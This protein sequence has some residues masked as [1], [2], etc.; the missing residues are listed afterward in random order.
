M[1]KGLKKIITIISCVSVMLLCLTFC[2]PLFMNNKE[3]NKIEEIKPSKG[4][5]ESVSIYYAKAEEETNAG[6]TSVYTQ[7]VYVINSTVILDIIFFILR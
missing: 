7:S 5:S 4:P 6:A 1:K 3:D 2:M